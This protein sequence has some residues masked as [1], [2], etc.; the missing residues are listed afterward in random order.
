M[1]SLSS[2]EIDSMPFY[3]LKKKKNRAFETFTLRDIS[4]IF[5][6]G[7]K[8]RSIFRILKFSNR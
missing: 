1:K 7:R 8:F 4:F 3:N 6:F 2:L 5:D